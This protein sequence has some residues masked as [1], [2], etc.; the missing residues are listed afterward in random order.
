ME[1]KNRLLAIIFVGALIIGNAFF[2]L[3]YFFLQKEVKNQNS[4]IA[5]VE[6]NKKLVNFYSLFIKKV[7]QAEQD[8]DFETRL[9]LENAVRDLNDEE[10]MTIWQYFTESKTEAEAQE[11]VKSLLGILVDRI[12]E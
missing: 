9:S 11:N 2:G 3:N 7:L 4:I 12:S 1:S 8:I 10:I 5:K 6:F